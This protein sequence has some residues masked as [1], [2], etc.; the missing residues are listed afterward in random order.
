[1]TK[2]K[3][4][5]FKQIIF[6]LSF[7][8]SNKKGYWL[9][10]LTDGGGSSISENCLALAYYL[11]RKKIKFKCVSN[12]EITKLKKNI[13][14]PLTIEYLYYSILARVLIVE[15]DLHNDLPGYRSLNT[16]KINLYHGMA[17]KKIYHSSKFVR[18][19]FIRNYKNILRKIIQGFCFTDEY[20]LISVTNKFFKKTYQKSFTNNRVEVLGQPRND[21]FLRRKK[22]TKIKLLKKLGLQNKKIKNIIIYLPTFRDKNKDFLNN[23]SFLTDPRLQEILNNKHSIILLKHHFFYKD[24]AHTKLKNYIKISENIYDLNNE[25][26]TRDLMNSSNLLITDYSSIYIDY[27]L[28]NKPI[29]FYCYDLQKYI[30][31]HRELNFN[32]YDDIFTPGEKIFNKKNLI[33]SIINQLNKNTKDKFKS[34]RIISR[35]FF[36]EHLDGNSSERI[37][38]Y[39]KQNLLNSQSNVTK[40]KAKITNIFR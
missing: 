30:K 34:K 8:I 33:S 6:V 24:Q 5:I 31:N 20:D 18:H 11:K 39:I 37:Y 4:I 10:S 3:K 16:F 19:L 7:F 22:N 38:E 9:L 25:F 40:G 29:I 12:V 1:M 23:K 15:S 28:I 32:Y 27:L 35:N 2:L 14:K 13:I 21:I 26:L 17:V 36:Y